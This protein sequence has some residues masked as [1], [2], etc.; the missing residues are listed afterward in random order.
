MHTLE[1]CSTQGQKFEVSIPEPRQGVQGAYVFAFAKSG[2]TLLNNLITTYCAAV[3]VPTLSLFDAAFGYGIPT[4]Q[5]GPDAQACFAPSGVIYTGF[6]H[7][8]RFDLDLGDANLVLLVRDPRDML[9]SMY[10]SVAKS[11]VVPKAHQRLKL[12]REKV[13]LLSIDEFALS[14]AE[15]LLRIFRNYQ[16]NLPAQ[17]LTTYRYEDVVFRK[18]WWLQ[19]LV[20]RLGLPLDE[21]LVE[22]VAHRFD[23]IPEQEDAQEHIRQVHPGDHRTKLAGSTIEKLDE[24]LHEFLSAYDY[25]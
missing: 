13:A 15:I 6:R 25:L 20:D 10:F 1:L 3:S 5:I 22:S 23:I 12:E 16:R 2:S 7:F 21:S 8:P 17:R 18:A 11:H 24:V 19:D 14:R 4:H 9:V